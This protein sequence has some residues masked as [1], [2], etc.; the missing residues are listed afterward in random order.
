MYFM[1]FVL[2]NNTKQWSICDTFLEIHFFTFCNLRLYPHNIYYFFHIKPDIYSLLCCCFSFCF[3]IISSFSTIFICNFTYLLFF[4]FIAYRYV[5]LLPYEIWWVFDFIFS[6]H[7]EYSYWR[8]TLIL[9]CRF[10]SIL[11]FAAFRRIS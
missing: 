11:G 9:K 6:N 10:N 5:C 7:F 3:T 1:I 8:F 2:K 4:T